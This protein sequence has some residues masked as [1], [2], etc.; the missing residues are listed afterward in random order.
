MKIAQFQY[1]CRLCGEEIGGISGD[2]RILKN[3][4]YNLIFEHFDAI[5]EDYAC[6]LTDTHECA[7]GS[8]GV[9]DLIGYKVREE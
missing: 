2:P 4:V 7:D 9:T 6:G 8:L 1:R 3:T 5:R